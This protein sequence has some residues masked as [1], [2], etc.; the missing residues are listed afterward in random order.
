MSCTQTISGINT[1][2]DSNVGG[3]VE[4]YAQNKSDITAITLT[5]GKVSALTLDAGAVAAAT[6]SFRKQ[7]GSLTST[8]NVDDAAGTQYVSSDLSLRFAKMETAKRTSVIALAH[9]ETILIVK[10]Q[11]GKYWLLGYDNPVTLSA[12]TG[13]TGTAM[14]DANE[15]A[16]TLNDISAEF[17]YEVV[18]AAVTT[19]LNAA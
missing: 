15:Y 1:S 19:F 9:A 4:V 18:S 7:T 11:N 6:L 13:S 8:I 2:C 14:G 5:D 3:I 10:D 17:P 16:L 12:G